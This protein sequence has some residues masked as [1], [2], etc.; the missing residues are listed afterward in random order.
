SLGRRCGLPEPWSLAGAGLLAASP[1][2]LYSSLWAMSDVPAAAWAAAALLAAWKSRE[3]PVWSL[4]CGLCLAV[5]FLVRPNNFLIALPIAILIGASPVRLLGVVGAA[6]PGVAAWLAINRSAYGAPLQ[7]GYGAIGNEFH[8][9]L[10]PGTLA[11][12]ARWLPLLLS[13]IIVAA[14]AVVALLGRTPRVAALLAAWIALYVGFYLPYR[15]THEDW[16]YLRFL[17]P[18]APAL[19]VAGLLVLETARRR[20]LP[21]SFGPAGRT[22]GIVLLL[23]ALGVEAATLD[24]LK[25]WTIGHGERK[26]LEA[27]AWLNAHLPPNAVV[28]STQ[29]S[30]SLHYYT[31][32]ALVRADQLGLPLARRVEAAARSA[33]DPV[34]AVFYPFERE[35]FA[36]LPGRWALVGSVEDISILRLEPAAP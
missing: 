7:S 30:G 29:F 13:P 4:V 8:L 14:P 31:P 24:R 10:V 28:V 27:G 9:D 32:F 34:Y 11:Y 1:L 3:R 22:L 17:L 18:A 23:A 20:L 33:G 2:Y 15:F 16:W 12:C 19:I 36:A 35:S 25:A 21:G 6:L 5:A 26:Y